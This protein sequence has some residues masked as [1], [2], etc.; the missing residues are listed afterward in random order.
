MSRAFS[1]G[2][3]VAETVINT[4][5]HFDAQMS[6]VFFDEL[7]LAAPD[8]DLG[9]RASL[10]GEMTGRMLEGVEKVLMEQ[11]P[12]AVLVYGDTNS[13]LAGALAG[14]KLQIPVVHCE[15]GMRTG[16]RTRPEEVNRIVVD[17][18][19][20]LLLCSTK[21]AVDNLA[22]EGLAERAVHVGDV[23]HD[24]TLH[25]R[26]QSIARSDILERLDLGEGGFHLLTLHRSENIDDVARFR[27]L[28]AYIGHM[29]DVGEVV[30]PVHP[31][32]RKQI[33]AA[34]I[35]A[36]RMR[37][38]DPLGYLDFHRLLSACS[39]V[40]TDSGGVQKEAY[41]H[42]K[43]CVTLRDETEWVETIEA[44]WNRLWTQGAYRSPRRDIEE[45]GA[46][47]AAQTCS[48]EIVNFVRRR[49]R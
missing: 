27:E 22:R 44:G 43:P 9:V 41:F 26:E 15:A 25:A 13:T 37:T 1:A 3:A 46:G 39:G 47:D 5:Q 19:A 7:G 8:F 28:L 23:M 34:G 14:A 2:G 21:A 49:R 16:N 17:H 40:L 32:T 11:R 12:D 48:E 24:V 42:R 36:S 38:I 4:G 33:E 30:F 35:D 20:D 45:Y 18:V 10:H 31:R 6:K 29:P